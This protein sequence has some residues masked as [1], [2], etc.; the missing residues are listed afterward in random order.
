MRLA[1]PP[2]PRARVRSLLKHRHARHEGRAGARTR[3]PGLQVASGFYYS[4]AEQREKMVEAERK[5]VDDKTKLVLDLK[6]KACTNG[7]TL[8]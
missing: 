5:W 7:E 1:S 3:P 4:N 8:V 2:H 6:R